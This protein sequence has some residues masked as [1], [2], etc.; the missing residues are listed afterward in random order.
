ML[1]AVNAWLSDQDVILDPPLHDRLNLSWAQIAD[2]SDSRGRRSGARLCTHR[3]NWDTGEGLRVTLYFGS[4]SGKEGADSAVQQLEGALHVV[5]GRLVDRA[6]ATQSAIV[7]FAHSLAR[8]AQALSAA[9]QQLREIRQVCAC[10]TIVP[11]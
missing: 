6:F 2:S 11:F 8:Q 9:N 3:F 4:R 7:H 5:V 10:C 1:I